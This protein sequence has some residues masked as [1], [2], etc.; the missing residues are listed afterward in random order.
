MP[1]IAIV[2]GAG[3]LVGSAA[4]RRFHAAGM[5]VVGIDSDQRR[6]FFG[7]AASTAGELRRLGRDLTRYR[8]FDVDIRDAAAIEAVFSRFGRDVAVIVHAAAQPSHDWAAGDPVQDFAI[9]AAGT[10]TMLEATRRH[11]PTAA[12]LFLST[13]KVYGDHP[14]RLPLR[15]EGTRLVLDP[16]H[17]F[18]AR[19]IDE[20]MSIDHAAHSLFGVSKTAADLYVQE[21]A[22]R[23]G[24]F[25]VCLRAGCLTGPGHRAAELH[26]FLA[27]LVK[28]AVAGAAYK[29]IGHGGFQVRDNLHATDLAEALYRIA[30]ERR[31]SAVY[32]I[33]GGGGL[34]CSV[35][36]ALDH[37]GSLLGR[38]IERIK[39]P[40]AR[41]GDHAW[42]ISDMS[43]F[44]ADYCG[45]QPKHTLES[46]F[47]ELVDSA[48]R[49]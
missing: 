37:A 10:L 21:Y 8:H 27:Y 33:G 17:P 1:S 7:P 34:S 26:G 45:W 44:Q 48:S 2:T 12:F 24:L 28:S 6:H 32:N 47:V 9:N 3:G 5:D 19:G 11:A 4:A 16:A 46:I 30:T 38:R 20:T 15:R 13:N 25:T 29:V 18:A 42:W 39:E 41:Y 40:E 36:E 31:R 14:N 49:E 35:N 22:S 43:R 23:Y